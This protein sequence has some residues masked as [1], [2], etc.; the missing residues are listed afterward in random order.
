MCADGA[1]REQFG[2]AA[3]DDHRLALAWPSKG[4]A[5]VNADAGIHWQRSGP[6]NST[7]SS[8]MADPASSVQGRQLHTRHLQGLCDVEHRLIQDLVGV[9]S[10]PWPYLVSMSI[11]TLT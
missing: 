3:H 11:I 10:A 8:L 6:A 7:F 1:D 5:S 4:T 2:A 9:S